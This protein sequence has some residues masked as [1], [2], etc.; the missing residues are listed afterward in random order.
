MIECNGCDASMVSNGQCYDFKKNELVPAIGTPIAGPGFPCCLA[1]KAK[2][3]GKLP[4][5]PRWDQKTLKR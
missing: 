2:C 1:W 5:V 3:D 4:K